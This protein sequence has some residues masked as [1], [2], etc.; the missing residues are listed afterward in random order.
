MFKR[1]FRKESIPAEA[2]NYVAIHKI[3]KRRREQFSDRYK[4]IY[5]LLR[6]DKPKGR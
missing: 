6:V 3:R 4:I 1:S 5:Y 2:A